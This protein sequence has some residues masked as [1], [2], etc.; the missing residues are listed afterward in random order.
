MRC[1]ERLAANLTGNESRPC[2]SMHSSQRTTASRT[3]RIYQVVRT[4][5][6]DLLPDGQGLPS[7]N[8]YQLG[9]DSLLA[10]QMRFAI[11]S[12]LGL[13]LP[14]TLLL[15]YPNLRELAEYLERQATRCSSDCPAETS[16]NRTRH[17]PATSEGCTALTPGQQSIW[18]D[19]QR[20]GGG[21]LYH[22]IA[23]YEIHG[24]LN[25]EA[26]QQA[27]DVVV[28]RH[29]A[30]RRRFGVSGGQ[31]FQNVAAKARITLQRFD[32]AETDGSTEGIRA[33]LEKVGREPFD[34]E[35][36][37]LARAALLSATP[38]RHYFLLVFHH[39]IIDGNSFATLYR[40]LELAYDMARSGEGPNLL[41]AG[42]DFDYLLY[43]K[44]AGERAGQTRDRALEFW[45]EHLGTLPITEQNNVTG[46]G[47]GG[48]DSDCRGED[49]WFRLPAGLV[50]KLDATARALETTRFVVLLASYQTIWMRLTGQTD[51]VVGAPFSG[52]IDHDLQ[53]PIGFFVNALPIRSRLSR[54]TR[55]DTLVANLKST[56]TTIFELQA[57]PGAN[58]AADLGQQGQP[59]FRKLFA[60][61]PDR[62]GLCLGGT[63]CQRFGVCTGTSKVDVAFLIF[64]DADELEI[65]IEFRTAAVTSAKV[66]TLL[67]SWRVLLEG[68]LDSPRTALGELPLLSAP[69]R[70]QLDQWSGRE[71]AQ[72]GF[73]ETLPDLVER[74]A[75]ETP[76]AVAARDSTGRTVSYDEIWTASR[77]VARALQTRGVRPGHRVGCRV[78]RSADTPALLLGILRA[79]AA[80]VTF[81]SGDPAVAGVLD[82]LIATNAGGPAL[83]NCVTVTPQELLQPREY[84][85]QP[86]VLSPDAAACLFF[87]SGTTGQ[88]KGSVISH[89]AVVRLVKESEFARFDTETV[90]LQLAPTAFDASTLEIW[91]PLA[92]G[93]TVVFAPECALSLSETGRL[94]ETERINTLWLTAGL[95]HLFADIEEPWL[96]GLHTLI[97]GGDVV[98]PLKARKILER[99]PHLRLING[100]GPTENTTFTCCHAISL[101]DLDG[102][103]IPLGTPIR[104]TEAHVL[105][106]K[107]DLLPPGCIGEICPGGDGLFLGYLMDGDNPP[108]WATTHPENR[109]VLYRTGDYGYWNDAGAL[110]FCGRRDRQV[111]IRGFRIELDVIEQQLATLPG[112]SQLA[113][114]VD[115]S[116]LLHPRVIAHYVTEP[117]SFTSEN[118]LLQAAQALLPAHQVPTRW[119][120]HSALPLTVR[121]KID[122]SALAENSC[123]SRTE[124]PASPPAFHPQI[125]QTIATIWTRLLGDV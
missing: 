15:Q 120:R 107:G 64:P 1:Q 11:E 82:L 48:D 71:H 65:L 45:K 114:E 53:D 61:Q 111:K 10:T 78:E 60:L 30:L 41:P 22:L 58:L 104:G 93:G 20:M 47:I 24:T 16:P 56:V 46:W 81:G 55:F 106:S 31:P 21:P 40:D 87:T 112:I 25:V 75:R 90:I 73:K 19:H 69:M 98:S 17:D 79:G 63:R 2:C 70:R 99:F 52:R 26:L 72:L 88:P 4:V 116:E 91:G 35:T 94:I 96:A 8:F 74:W 29:E 122:R 76:L 39:L 49:A 101:A 121:G 5:W 115:R 85:P 66:N 9:G 92:N 95:F 12:A 100:Y 42:A 50:R 118:A 14:L 44:R 123:A 80:Y 84:G 113:V 124:A 102:S 83:G 6:R 125:E 117:A 103:S 7:E 109:S 34:L 43:V 86:M 67:D 38:D 89:R 13:R 119:V 3:P 27:L 32:S 28:D 68:A 105:G 108:H 110:V 77:H 33:L 97:T 54:D 18:L 51:G 23:D 57:Y 36:P 37:P 59:L 62:R